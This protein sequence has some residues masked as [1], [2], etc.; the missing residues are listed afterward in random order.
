MAIDRRTTN[1]DPE[2][3]K[4]IFERIQEKAIRRNEDEK[5]A[6]SRHQRHA[7][8]ALRSRIK[9]LEPPMRPT[10]TWAQVRPRLEKL[11]EF[12]AIESEELRQTAFEKVL[13]R[14]KEK[15]EDAEK[16]RELRDRARGPR[17]DHPDRVDRDYR[18]GQA[19]RVE[20]RAASTRL[21]RT[22]EPDPYEADR[23]KAQADRERS[24]RKASGLS[25]IRD[26]RDERERDR[27]RD[28]EKDRDRDRDR[29]RERDRR[30]LSHYE[31]E[32]RDREEERERL[33][34]TRGDPRGS[35]DELDYGDSRSTVS[36]DRRRRRDSDAESVTS[37][38]AKRY[39]REAR[40]RER[41]PDRNRVGRRDRDRD[42]RD[43]TSMET[44]ILKK[45]EKAVHSGSEEGEIE[46]D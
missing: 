27:D 31:R 17:R 2:T 36:T 38:S 23:R 12:K 43:R 34:R 14:L 35:R 1:I 15:E 39:R 25:P 20:R 8:D 40:E 28:R 22:P 46:E 13:R 41:T 33:Y 32:R 9:R 45:E 16:E 44:E 26:K 18:N 6:A 24:Y 21:S 4:L 19:Y 29:E 3:L 37:R 5:H 30:H 42:R 11:D 10:D 7:I